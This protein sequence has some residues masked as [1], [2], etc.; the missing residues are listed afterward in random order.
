MAD[1]HT[2]AQI[3]KRHVIGHNLGIMDDKF[4]DHARDARVGETIHLVGED[5][6]QFA[7][8][9]QCVV[10]ALDAWL[11][12]GIPATTVLAEVNRIG[13]AGGSNS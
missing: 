3:Q 10:D 5:I 2:F 11:A 8:V 13:V 7:A 4:A 6:R 9:A 1:M 12:G